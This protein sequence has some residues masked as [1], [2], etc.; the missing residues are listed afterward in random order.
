MDWLGDIKRRFIYS[1]P[2]GHG[3]KGFVMESK[4]HDREWFDVPCP[5]C[6]ARLEY[7]RFENV[8][9]D[10]GGFRAPAPVMEFEQNGRKAVKIGGMH[11]SK[12]K[13]NYM[14]NG[15]IENAY[16]EGFKAKLAKEAAETTRRD[17]YNTAKK[18]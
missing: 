3:E 17:A 5:I 9:A 2:N 15:T 1:C 4:K 16:T 14:E 8:S 10:E 12:T 13:H 11:M 7:R 18:L 6:D